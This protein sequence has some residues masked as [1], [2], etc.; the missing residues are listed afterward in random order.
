MLKFEERYGFFPSNKR[1]SGE[2][3]PRKKPQADVHLFIMSTVAYSSRSDDDDDHDD[4]SP[5]L[6]LFAC[7]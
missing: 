6:T 1:S 3:S 5:N 2:K 4:H 7:I